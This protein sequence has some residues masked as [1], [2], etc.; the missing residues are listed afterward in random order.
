MSSR[1]T[2]LFPGRRICWFSCGAASA[3]AAKIALESGPCEVIYC[4]TSKSEHSDN[5]RFLADVERWLGL[6]VIVIASRFSTVDQ[7]FEEMRYMSGKDGARCTT[8]MKK[9]PRFSYQQPEDVHIFGYTADEGKRIRLFEN[10][11]PE[12][13]TEWPLVERGLTKADTLRIIIEA[14]IELPAMYQLGYKNN[15]CLG[16]VKAQS[17]KYWNMIRRDFP[18]VF[19]RRCEQSR[20]LGVRLVTLHGERIFLADL[21]ND[22]SE[23]IAE[24]LSC[25]PQCSTVES[26]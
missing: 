3:V 5:A 8:E 13:L 20:A 9:K 18:D 7:V 6:K 16:C 2:G 26:P 12:L 17:P 1:Q 4:D 22:T 15:N 23:E 14:G 19:Q 10:N 24:D 21:P 11:N 25:G